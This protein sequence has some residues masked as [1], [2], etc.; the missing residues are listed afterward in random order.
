VRPSEFVAA[1]AS[2]ALTNPSATSSH[3][4]SLKHVQH[5]R[6]SGDSASAEAKHGLQQRMGISWIAAASVLL[7]V[8]LAGLAFLLWV[9]LR[10]ATGE[11][12]P[13]A[14]RHC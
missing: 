8:A 5:A 6:A 3:A 11:L 2:A 7:L 1:S 9:Q 14:P 13:W 12:W 10:P 4:A